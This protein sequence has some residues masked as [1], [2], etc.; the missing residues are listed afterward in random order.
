[1]ELAIIIIVILLVYFLL[2]KKKK[3]NKVK[4][5]T[6]VNFFYTDFELGIIDEVNRY[7]KS[8]NIQEVKLSN[9]ISKICLEHNT[10][11]QKNNKPSHD[12]FEERSERIVSN[13]EA[14]SVGENVAFNFSTPKATLYAWLQSPSHKENLENPKWNIMGISNSYKYTTNIFA[15]IKN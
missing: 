2:I 9:Y 13:L 11:M 7:R 3:I 8:L 1:M 10:Y 4:E 15:E 6:Y 5:N 12:N 14:D